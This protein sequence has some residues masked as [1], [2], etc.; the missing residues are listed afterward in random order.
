MARLPGK[1]DRSLSTLKLLQR[2][3]PVLAMVC[4]P[5]ILVV[6]AELA[7]SEDTLWMD[8]VYS[9]AMASFDLRR[10]A[11][12]A[13]QDLHPPLYYLALHSWLAGLDSLSLSRSIGAV[14]ALN[15]V[16]WTL[17]VLASWR[18][19]AVA[20]GPTLGSLGALLVG[21]SA[22]I[23]QFTQD[24]RSYGFAVAGIAICGYLIALDVLDEA[25]AQRKTLVRTLSYALSASVAA[26]SHLLSWLLLALLGATWLG[27]RWHFFR[28]RHRAWYGPPVAGSAATF[29]LLSPW[30]PI[31]L[32]RASA[33]QSAAPQWMTPASFLNLGR[34]FWEWLPFGRDGFPWLVLPHT[35]AFSMGVLSLVPLG[36]LVLPVPRSKRSEKDQRQMRLRWLAVGFG[37]T[38]LGFVALLWGSSRFGWLALFHGP[39]YPCLVVPL[40]TTALLLAQDSEVVYLR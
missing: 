18:M 5:G 29:L 27:L 1:S 30:I 33:L 11:D 19:L 25:P 38:C 6:K 20:L 14:R 32:E 13:V 21:C 28:A 36:L 24:A 12:F 23:I 22:Q 34:V 15:L 16:V 8:E 7:T 17:L 40:W 4:L 37:A 26:W 31:A 39:R 35:M 9:L 2:L 10:L 3:I